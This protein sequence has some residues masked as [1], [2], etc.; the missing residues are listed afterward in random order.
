VTQPL[1]VLLAQ[2]LLPSQPLFTQQLLVL[3][4]L[5]TVTRPLPLQLLDHLLT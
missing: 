4:H 5:L 2:L 1:L 3:A